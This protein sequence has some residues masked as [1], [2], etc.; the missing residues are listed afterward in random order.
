[1]IYV[2]P[3]T[4]HAPTIEK[5]RVFEQEHISRELEEELKATLNFLKKTTTSTT[6]PE[7]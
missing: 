5:I 3:L 7:P 4:S 1:V 2:E 6:K